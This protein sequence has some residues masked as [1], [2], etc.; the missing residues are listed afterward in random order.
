MSTRIFS[1]GC[2]VQVMHRDLKLA[3]MLIGADGILKVGCRSAS[4]H[5]E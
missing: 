2:F 4:V 5:Q 1:L 3:N